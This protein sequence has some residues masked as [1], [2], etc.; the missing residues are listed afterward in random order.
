MKQKFAFYRH[1]GK[2]SLEIFFRPS[3]ILQTLIDSG[4]AYVSDDFPPIDLEFID[5][6]HYNPENKEFTCDHTSIQEMAKMLLSEKRKQA[7]ENLD[8]EQIKYLGNP[9]KLARIESLKQNLR[10]LPSTIDFTTINSPNDA[11]HLRPP[12][13]ETYLEDINDPA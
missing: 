2:G 3:Q 10:D 5:A 4:E 6:F 13:L 9:E 12:I 11:R 1:N 8:A 7:L